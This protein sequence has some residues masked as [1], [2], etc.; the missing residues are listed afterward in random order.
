MTA[1]IPINSLR[2]RK[3]RFQYVRHNSSTT[4]GVAQP[5]ERRLVRY[6]TKSDRVVEQYN[7]HFKLQ[8]DG[9]RQASADSDAPSNITTIG[10]TPRFSLYTVEEQKPP[11]HFTAGSGGGDKFGTRMRSLK[12]DT[13]TVRTS[14]ALSGLSIPGVSSL[15]LPVFEGPSNPI[16]LNEFLQK[17]P[18]SRSHY[19]STGGWIFVKR[20]NTNPGYPL[21]KADNYA[22]AE[23]AKELLDV[24]T[25]RIESY[26]DD[27]ANRSF[28]VDGGKDTVS[29]TRRSQKRG[30]LLEKVFKSAA[31]EL[32][33]IAVKY[34]YK[35]GGWFFPM[36]TVRSDK[37]FSDL[38][39]SL[40]GGELQRT[41][42]HTVKITT[43]D[44]PNLPPDYHIVS[45]MVPD[46]W[47]KEANKKV[48]DVLVNIYGLTPSGCKPE[49]FI[50]IG[51]GHLHKTGGNTCTFTPQD[52]YSSHE[53][54]K[55]RYNATK[56]SNFTRREI[57]GN[58]RQMGL[59][60]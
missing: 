22:C 28:H 23:R 47:D 46:A 14:G 19:N 51:Y 41:F 11:I 21:S 15:T 29:E 54:S 32:K 5:N 53:L 4:P 31:Q 55:A 18:P 56:L 3:L 2:L 16:R 10:E 42:A 25:K 59:M 33:D 6:L 17:Y 57:L 44:V 20:D 60:D 9:P 38:S 50:Q 45:V 1:R 39:R 35:C 40:I 26:E 43:F 30:Y 37:V 13:P 49:L 36:S 7:Y 52:F 8:G 27:S 12:L 34:N 58:R 24:T 48:L